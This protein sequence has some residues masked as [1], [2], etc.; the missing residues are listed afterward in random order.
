MINKE[1]LPEYSDVLHQMLACY[2]SDQ[3]VAPIT[4]KNSKHYLKRT[5]KPISKWVRKWI[6]PK[7]MIDE[8]CSTSLDI[9]RVQIHTTWRF[10]LIPVTR[11][12]LRKIANS[13][14]W[15]GCTEECIEHS[16]LLFNIQT[17]KATTENLYRG[18]SNTKN[19]II[20]WYR[21]W[22]CTWRITIL[23]T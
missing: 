23:E 4:C 20:R 12:I 19:A 1:H 16:Y 15:E 2:S 17:S 8:K 3:G 18:S 21:F 5:N 6:V 10:Q 13:G 22:V 9:R 14:F 7:R 11:A